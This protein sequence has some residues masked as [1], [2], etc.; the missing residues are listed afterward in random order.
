MPDKTDVLLKI[1][2]QITKKTIQMVTG[3]INKKY[4]IPASK[5]FYRHLC[6]AAWGVYGI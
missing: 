5:I 3:I 1:L 4:R 2:K 6:P